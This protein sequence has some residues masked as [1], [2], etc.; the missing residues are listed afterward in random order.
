MKLAIC[1]IK[2][3]LKFKYYSEIKL[4]TASSHKLNCPERDL[5]SLTN[6][7]FKMDSTKNAS[8]NLKP[9][10]H[11]AMKYLKL[12]IPPHEYDFLFQKALFPGCPSWI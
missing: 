3:I 8:F 9:S 1:K 11:E 5:I 2:N 12:E 7:S 10:S 4:D 6:K